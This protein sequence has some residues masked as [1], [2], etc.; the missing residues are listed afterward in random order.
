MMN[1]EWL[2]L[3]ELAS[4][5][6]VDTTTVVRHLDALGLIGE[7]SLPSPMAKAH[8][9]GQDE[10][11]YVTASGT[12]H[13]D[14]LRLLEGRGL[15]GVEATPDMSGT[16]LFEDEDEDMLPALARAAARAKGPE[17]H[18]PEADRV[19][20]PS[21]VG[22]PVPGAQRY[23]VAQVIATDGAC[24]GNPGPGGW[25]WVDEMTGE[26]GS[27]GERRTTNNIME[28]TAMLEAIRH[29]DDDVELLIRSDSQYVINVV[30]KWAPGWRKRGWK[31]ADGKPVANQE[32]IADLMAAYEGRTA[33]TRID[34]VRGHDG[35]E[36]NE[37]A[38]KLA[39]SERDRWS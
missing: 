1:E 37:R 38:D 3:S 30:T 25:A 9:F 34:W 12:W 11:D 8:G 6:G 23:G 39:V 26:S 18:R 20:M 4:R 24:S 15:T 31:K 2:S 10:G 36:G 13:V 7:G 17:R 28:L 16:S 21:S 32:L 35:D 33:P 14:T 5:C 19:D 22:G 29:A 27:G